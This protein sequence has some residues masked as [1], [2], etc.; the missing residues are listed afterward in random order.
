MRACAFVLYVCVCLCCLSGAQLASALPR[1]DERRDVVVSV[2][3]DV[4]VAY[5]SAVQDM[6]SVMEQ[7]DAA[8]ASLGWLKASNASGPRSATPGM[9]APM[10]KVHRV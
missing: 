4:T 9:C 10:C 7:M 2:V 3:R 5:A 1:P 8:A 6:L